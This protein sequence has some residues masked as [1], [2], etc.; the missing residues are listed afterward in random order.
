M[1]I[2]IRLLVM[3]VLILSTFN[4]R[5][6]SQISCSAPWFGI[7]KSY[8]FSAQC[9]VKV[10]LC[11]YCHPEAPIVD[12][13]A[14]GLSDVCPDVSAATIFQFVQWQVLNDYASFC[15]SKP[16]YPVHL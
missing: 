13:I 5:S 2:F 9:T 7:T 4:S 12:I 6:Y 3:I 8:I 11:V 10:H 1:K 14:M 16:C 15:G